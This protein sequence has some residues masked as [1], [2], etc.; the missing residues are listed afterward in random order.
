MDF[1]FTND[2][3]EKQFVHLGSY[4]IGITRVMGVIVE[5]LSD[6][7][8]I[9][10][11][12]SVT[13]FAVHLIQLGETVKDEAEKLYSELTAKGIEVFFD[14]RAEVMAGEKFADADLI[15]IPLRV[16]VSERSLQNGGFEVKGRTQEKGE[17][18]SKEALLSQFTAR[19]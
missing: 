11:P 1:S 19:V 2:A 7:K 10:W 13:P 8:G 3:G 12:E 9:V 18:F 6:E 16:V 4:G 5:K 14:D 17:I 15:G